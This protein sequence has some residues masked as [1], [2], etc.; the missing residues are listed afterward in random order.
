[1]DY[2]DLSRMKEDWY[3]LD[4]VAIFQPFPVDSLK[5][6]SSCYGPYMVQYKCMSGTVSFGNLKTFDEDN[7]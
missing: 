1:M 3:V 5:R 6:G 4:V 2:A 7:I